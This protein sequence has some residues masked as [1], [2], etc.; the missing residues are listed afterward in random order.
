M[1]I[2]R[3]RETLIAHEG[4]QGKSYKCTAGVETIGYG[5]A[6]KDLALD[7]DICNII[8]D[9]K[10]NDLMMNMYSK[11][12]WMVKHPAKV[13]EVMMDCAYQMGI[14][15]FGKFKKTLSYIKE[16][17]YILAGEELLDSRYAK[18]T[19]NRAKENSEILKSTPDI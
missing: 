13:Q 16:G 1:N 12:P 2:K 17:E 10:I 7:T 15:G 3:L 5:F 19:P 4:Y 14:T 11:Y 6:I 8:L 9:R 18:Q